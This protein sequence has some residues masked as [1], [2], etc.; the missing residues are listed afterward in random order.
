MTGLICVLFFNAIFLTNSGSFIMIL[1]A[2]MYV[3]L[4][5]FCF[6]FKFAVI[7]LDAKAK[8]P[9]MKVMKHLVTIVTAIILKAIV[10]VNMK[11]IPVKVH[12]QKM[13]KKKKSNFCYFL[14]F[15]IK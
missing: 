15:L 4:H 2:V 5:L 7:N 9:M 11:M 13:M 6:F 1:S 12:Q 3:L 10:I 14:L 8:Q